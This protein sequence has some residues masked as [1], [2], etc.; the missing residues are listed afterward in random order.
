VRPERQERQPQEPPKFQLSPYYTGIWTA[1]TE[2]VELRRRFT[3]E[4]RTQWTNGFQ[5][6][7]NGEWDDAKQIFKNIVDRTMKKQGQADGPA[8]F[9]FETICTQRVQDW[10]GYRQV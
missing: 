7:V 5:H 9:L 10:Q 4:I 1:D 3:D 8:A 6:Y 2:L